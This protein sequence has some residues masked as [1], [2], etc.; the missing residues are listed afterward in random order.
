VNVLDERD[1]GIYDLAVKCLIF[2][3]FLQMGLASSITP[4]IFGKLKDAGISH[5]T[6][7]I[8]RYYNV[9]TALTGIVTPLMVV[10][11][12]LIVPLII[13]D[14]N[15]YEAFSF[16]GIIGAG[17][18]FKGLYLQF[19]NVLLFFK[20]TRFLPW[21]L[22]FSSIVHVGLTVWFVRW[23]GITGA[24]WANL[25]AK[26]F[27]IVFLYYYG[28]K[29]FQFK[30]NTFKMIWLPVM[31]VLM[32]VVFQYFVTTYNA[33]LI[34]TVQFLVSFGLIL[35]VYRKELTAALEKWK[36]RRLLKK[37]I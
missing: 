12:P 28:R 26:P 16:I 18:L 14:A 35:L 23:W 5:S 17:Y 8:N 2:I 37:R 34:Y 36:Q 19:L 7:D 4:V 24:A 6:T 22:F 3:E 31:Y 11:V 33:V 1:V 27:Q 30:L 21:I 10:L 9:F 20:Q 32:V 25:A 15:Y 29:F 13:R